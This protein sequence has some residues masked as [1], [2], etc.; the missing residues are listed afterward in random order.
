MVLTKAIRLC[1]RMTVIAC[2]SQCVAPVAWPQQVAPSD[3]Q[4]S[5]S[6]PS[7]DPDSSST[8]GATNAPISGNSVASSPGPF[9][10]LAKD[11]VS[12]QKQIWTSPARLRLPD[13]QWLLPLSGITAGL[14][15]T[16][17]DFNAHLSHNSTTI[18]HYKTLSDASVGA[19]IGGA[20]GMWLLGHASHNNHWI[21]TGFLSGEAALNSLLVVESMKYPFGRERPYQANGSSQFFQGA[22]SFPSEHAATAW[23]IAGVLAHE[24]P[25]P[26]MKIAAYGLAGLVDYSR[27]HGQQHFP[28]DV[29]V[30]SLIGNFI[31]QDI[32][33][34]GS[35]QDFGGVAWSSIGHFVRSN[36]KR[37]PANMGSPYVPPDSWTYPLFD[38]LIALGYIQTAITGM[39][40]WT[41]LE[42]ARLLNEAEDRLNAKGFDDTSAMQLYDTLSREFSKDLALLDGSENNSIQTESVYTSVTGISGQPLTDGNHF[43]QTIANNYGRPYEQG[44]N[45]VEGFSG[46]ATSGSLVGYVRAE[47]QHS[48]SAPAAPQAA[49]EFIASVDTVPGVPPATV[50]AEINRLQ[51]LDS[52]VGLNFENWQ[53]SYGRQSLWWGPGESGPLLFSDN[54]VPLNLFRVNRVSPF[55]LPSIFA[56]FGPMR[57]EWFLGQEAGHQFVFRADT[58]TVGQFGHAI[59]RQPFFQGQKF[60]FK[61]T[62]NFEFGVYFTVVFSGGPTPL[63]LH[64]FFKSYSIGANTQQGGLMDPG[65][66]R[67]GVNFAYRIPG[68]RKWLTLYGDAFTEDEFSP[69]GYPRKS[70]YEGGI[71]FPR[72]PG[73]RKL[74]LRAEGGSTV[75]PDFLG[76]VGC[77]YVNNRYPDGSYTSNGNLMGSWLGRASQGEQGWA[78]YWLSPRN[79]IQ[80]TYRHQ[81]VSSTYLPGGGTLNDAGV[82]ADFWLGRDLQLS[83]SM[84]YEKWNYPLLTP[85]PQTD[86]VTSVGLHF[87]PHR[88]GMAA[89]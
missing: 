55:R 10:S 20:G 65:D 74:D 68:L 17:R 3:E 78:T 25:G 18:G 19:L 77:F 82:S 84:Q 15:V 54:S 13:V 70:A 85:L 31:A 71:Y 29:L 38:R 28:S 11:F 67:S 86:F 40:P 61:P 58:G 36:R 66:A 42:C 12:D 5:L 14:F 50:H 49:R 26:L 23:S 43:G 41:R 48:P 44:F 75:P 21:E 51:F 81:R 8:S 72:I 37:M 64:Y 34:R 27:V 2:L 69:L 33:S 80:F 76:C 56:L 79:R 83:G 88:W 63:T 47:Y 22:T 24:Y 57:F 9:A 30:G 60:S 6:A 7:A 45:A 39:R 87:W 89:N 16:D 73:I 46:W 52:Y 35:N 32:Y 53:V 1:G 59:A 4:P 62:E